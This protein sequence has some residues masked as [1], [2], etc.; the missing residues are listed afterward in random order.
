MNSIG[1]QRSSAWLHSESARQAPHL[2]TDV[3]GVDVHANVA[4]LQLLAPQRAASVSAV[5]ATQVLLASLQTGVAERWVQSPSAS[6]PPQVLAAVSQVDAVGDV[7]S[8]L[9]SQATQ[10][11][12][13]HAGVEPPQS[14]VPRHS[15]Q[16]P[17]TSSQ[18]GVVP[19]HTPHGPASVATSLGASNPGAS[20]MPPS[21]GTQ[22]PSTRVSLGGQLGAPQ[23]VISAVSARYRKVRWRR[24]SDRQRPGT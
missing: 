23:A 8:A 20:P 12:I 11:P 16:F 5:Q 17:L 19:L 18:S 3:R 24:S 6:Q 10:L 14:P 9:S 21:A 1:T 15:T 2:R 4:G 13:T 22:R 7:Q